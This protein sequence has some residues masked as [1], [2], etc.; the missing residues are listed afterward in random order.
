MA[1]LADEVLRTRHYKN[2]TIGR[3]KLIQCE[4]KKAQRA[5]AYA[6]PRNHVLPALALTPAKARNRNLD[7]ILLTET[8]SIQIYYSDRESILRLSG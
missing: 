5:A 6:L 3:G 1:A 8:T 4:A 2:T 7:N